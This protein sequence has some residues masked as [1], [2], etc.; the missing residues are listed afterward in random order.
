MLAVAALAGLAGCTSQPAA[1]A[2]QASAAPL[3]T[4]AEKSGLRVGVAVDTDRLSDSAYAKLTAQQFSTVTPEN[5]MKWEVVEPKQGQYDWSAADKLVDFA[6]A[7]GQLVR[8]HN[9]V[10]YS[11]LP[12][13]LTDEAPSL[14]ADQL[15]AILQKHITDEV[16]HFTGKIWQWDVV[17][18]AFDDSGNLRDN[19]WIEKLGPDYIADAFRWAH[20]AD[21]DAKLFLNDYGIE[22]DGLKSQAEYDFVKQLVAQ[23]VPIDGVGFETH[24]DAD[25]PEQDLQT[26]MTQYAKLGIDVAITEADVKARTPVSKIDK[27]IQSSM[28]ADSMSAC[29]AVKQCI[30]YTLWDLDDK[31]SWIPQYFPGEGGA[32][33]YDDELKPKP[34]YVALQQA[35]AKG[36]KTAPP[37]SK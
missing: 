16:T 5:A 22:T 28:F 32:T 9:L 36:V 18:E 7:H 24:L 13:W 31:D 33:L 20:A 17:N 10:W 2:P 26:V 35:L 23:G 1:T 27:T 37:R 34:Q 19:I 14:T 6:Q 12:Q 21:P 11:Q 25:D 30:S 3:R 8:G 4:I 29:L 15:S